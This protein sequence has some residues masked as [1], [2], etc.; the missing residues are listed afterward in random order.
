[1]TASAANG[2]GQVKF[3]PHGTTCTA[4]AVR[5]PP[6]VLHVDP[7]H[8]RAVG[9]SDVQHRHRHRDRT[10]RLL[11]ARRPRSAVAASARKG[12]YR[13]RADRRRRRRLLPPAASTLVK[14]SGCY[15][16]EHRI[17]RH[18]VPQR[19]AEREPRPHPDTDDLHQPA[20]GSAYTDQYAAG[21]VQH[22]PA[23]DRVPDLQ[24]A[25]G[26]GCTLIPPTDDGTPGRVLPLLLQRDRP[27]RLRV[28]GRSGRARLHDERLRQER[29]VRVVAEG[30]LPECSAARRSS[31]TTTSS[32]SCRT[33]PV[34]RADLEGARRRVAREG[35]PPSVSTSVRVAFW[36][37]AIVT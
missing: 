10:L 27:G 5:L 16:H 21:G 20:T 3:A 36:V 8:H 33:T 32:R 24:P 12:T 18:V 4:H 9:R 22:R 13:R 26:T 30:R 6:D 1:M 14:V 34:R 25:T 15:G 7:P 29:P 35:D 28:D 19:L 17:R 37:R 31:T 11:P 23:A 2:F